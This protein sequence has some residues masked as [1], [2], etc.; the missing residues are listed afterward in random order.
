MEKYT[1]REPESTPG[2]NA[3]TG[4]ASASA[5]Q[6]TIV[7]VE[8]LGKIFP[9]LVSVH[10]RQS[11]PPQPRPARAGP[12]AIGLRKIFLKPVSAHR[13]RET[14]PQPKEA[15]LAA[16]AKERQ[17]EHGQTAPGK[18]RTLG[19]NFSQV[20]ERCSTLARICKL[21]WVV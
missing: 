7:A 16:L 13:R 17:R 11:K 21:R 14:P 3:S 4:R 1:W 12:S 6:S 8:R 10:R 5:A 15:K 9:K 2:V 18:P 20:I 19:K